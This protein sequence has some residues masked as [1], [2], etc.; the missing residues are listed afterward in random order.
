MR[1]KTKLVLAITGLVFP[2]VALSFVN[3]RG[4]GAVLYMLVLGVM[5]SLA[6]IAGLM[7][8]GNPE[9]KPLLSIANALPAAGFWVTAAAPDQFTDVIFIWQAVIAAVVLGVAMWRSRIYW[10]ELARLDGLARA[11]KK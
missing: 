5:S 10:H 11:S 1:L 3:L 9:L 4:R 8:N 7:A 6:A 2:A